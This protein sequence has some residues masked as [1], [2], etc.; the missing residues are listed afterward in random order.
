M[1]SLRQFIYEAIR[2]NDTEFEKAMRL[3]NS[4][5][6]TDNIDDIP[7]VAQPLISYDYN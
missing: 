5:G 4:R 3:D 1:K 6:C 7:I 2:L